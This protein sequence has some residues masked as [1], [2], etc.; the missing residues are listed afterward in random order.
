MQWDPAGPVARNVPGVILSFPVIR[1]LSL[2][3]SLFDQS[4]QFHLSIRVLFVAG[5]VAATLNDKGR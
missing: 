3:L 1:L 5:S 4:D 2:P